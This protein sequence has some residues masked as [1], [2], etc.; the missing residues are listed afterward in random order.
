MREYFS[1]YT[2][3]YRFIIDDYRFMIDIINLKRKIICRILR[4]AILLER[5]NHASVKQRK[6]KIINRTL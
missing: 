5:E 2:K 4:R 3:I 1:K 6:F